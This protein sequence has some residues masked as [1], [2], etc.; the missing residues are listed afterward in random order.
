MQELAFFVGKGGVGKTTVS[1]AYAI[2]SALRHPTERVLLLSTDPAHSLADVLQ[3]PLKAEPR[4]IP[5]EKKGKLSAW[6]IDAERRFRNF[7][8]Q[9]R[10]NI[11]QV[12]EMGSIFTR[13]DIEPLIDSTLPGMAEVA[14]LLA[15]HDAVQ[16]GEYS[17]VIVDTAPFGHTLRLFSL[18][19]Q[20]VRFL[21]FLELSAN[22]DQVLASH[23][24]GRVQSPII[25]FLSEW[26]ALIEAIQR[27]ITQEA[28]I[29]LVTTA[30]KFSLNESVRCRDILGGYSPPIEISAIV[31]NRV[32]TRPSN[33]GWCKRRAAMTRQ[34][35]QFLQEHFPGSR[36]FVAEDPGSPIIGT[37]ALAQFADHVFSGK[38]LQ[39][40]PREPRSRP[41]KLRKAHWP[42]LDADLS[43]VLGK[44]G[45]G[46]TTVS[47]ALGLVTRKKTESAVEICSVDPAPS[48]DDVFQKAIGDDPTPVLGDDKFRASELD[49]VALFHRWVGELKSN[50]DEATT[51]EVSG[52]HVDLSFERRLLELLLDIVPPGVDEVLAIFRILDLLSRSGER[53]LIDMAP[54]GHGLELLRMPDRIL[55]WTRPLLKTLA[56]H[57]TLAM[58]REAGVKI[59]EL[60]HRVRELVAFLHEPG[61]AQ[62]W[63]VMLPEPLPDRETERLT[64]QLRELH[65]PAKAIFVNRVLFA[66]DVGHCP[67]CRRAM[68]SQQA[69]LAALKRRYRFVKIYVLRNFP[70]EI[71]GSAALNSFTRE[72]W[73]LK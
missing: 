72:L 47:A 25:R 66:E 32:V 31:L 67:R 58:A 55:S 73:E 69:T 49:S 30:E 50:V 38:P 10:E 22:R 12:V 23:F 53:V 3:V 28:K 19:E 70:D 63:T 15:I 41:V 52:I 57:R 29:S 17:R 61:K 42:A 68:G 26:R 34:A 39:L 35:K 4:N 51:A 45:V 54:T 36:T 40:G 6:Q 46:K 2:H 18:P 9:Y 64:R 62:V 60:A 43:F 1:A 8:N 14:A 48:L 16:S 13:E 20:F 44:G 37:A 24:G 56:L 71:A 7:L 5:L 21:E 11:L 33:C 59:A 65:L 27:A